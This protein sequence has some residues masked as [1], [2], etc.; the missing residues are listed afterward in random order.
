[1]NCLI[2]LFASLPSPLPNELPLWFLICH[3]TR[4]LSESDHRFLP[5][6]GQNPVGIRRGIYLTLRSIHLGPNSRIQTLAVE[7]WTEFFDLTR[8]HFRHF[9]QATKTTKVKSSYAATYT[10]RKGYRTILIF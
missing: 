3:P 2:F 8:Q 9:C 6:I 5:Q 7:F 10:H 1:M 4:L